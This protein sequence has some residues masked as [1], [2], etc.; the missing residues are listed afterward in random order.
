L[1]RIE[2]ALTE[3]KR[4]SVRYRK[5]E[6]VDEFV[7]EMANLELMPHSVLTFL[8]MADARLWDNTVFYHHSEANHVV[9]A[10][11]VVFGTF[12]PKHHHGS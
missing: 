5:A 11:P 8:D 2:K 3:S 12:E 7:L 1:K 9:A 4:F 6:D 10:A